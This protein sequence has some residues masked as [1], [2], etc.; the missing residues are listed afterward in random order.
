MTKNQSK[1]SIPLY[2][3]LKGVGAI[4]TLTDISMFQIPENLVCPLS[5]PLCGILGVV[6]WLGEKIKYGVPLF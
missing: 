3:K 4:F 2:G 6:S 5:F 1:I